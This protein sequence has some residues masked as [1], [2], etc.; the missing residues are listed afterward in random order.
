MIGEGLFV[1]FPTIIGITVSFLVGLWI[2]ILVT[3]VC[4]VCSVGIFYFLPEVR[5]SF[6][7]YL[8]REPNTQTSAPLK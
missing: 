7:S 5:Y 3:I 8:K 4:V 2:G 1:F 6:L